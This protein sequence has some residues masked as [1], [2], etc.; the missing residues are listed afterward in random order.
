MHKG[1]IDGAKSEA[2]VKS[3]NLLAKHRRTPI[4]QVK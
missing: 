2:R 4:G 3:G 1:L